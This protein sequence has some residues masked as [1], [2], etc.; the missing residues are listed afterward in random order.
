MDIGSLIGLIA[1]TVFTL[2]T[3]IFNGDAPVESIMAFVDA[4][5]IMIVIGGVFASLLIANPLDRVIKALMSAKM[6]FLPPKFDHVGTIENIITLSNLARREGVLALEESA[7]GMD[8]PFLQKGIML[9]VDGA[10]PELV[11]SV[12]E[13]EMVF[14]EN[15]HNDIRSLWDM[16]AAMAP[17]WGMVG[18][19]VALVLMMGNLQDIELLAAN[20]AL[21]MITTFYG[22]LVANFIASPIS[23]KLQIFNAQE[24][25]LKE[26]QIEGM[27]S[28]QNGENPRIIE[29]KLKAFLAP[30]LRKISTEGGGDA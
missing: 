2:L 9:V 4:G 14:M 13:T 30:S 23:R 7:Q 26:V 18:T 12:L 11:R 22:A 1:G 27:L 8:D 24:M 16:A 17:A 19:M 15:R 20:M 21:A 25:L 6:V 5:S 10:D 29:E 28:I 3:I